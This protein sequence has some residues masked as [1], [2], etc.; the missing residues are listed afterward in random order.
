MH[1]K[2]FEMVEMVCDVAHKSDKSQPLSF[3]FVLQI[4]GN[5]IE[6]W[7]SSFDLRHFSLPMPNALHK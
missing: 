3:K 5:E 4:I 1:L 2:C 7:S 6:L